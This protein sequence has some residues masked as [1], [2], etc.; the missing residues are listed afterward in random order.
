MVE[1]RDFIGQMWTEFTS[2]LVQEGWNCSDDSVQLRAGVWWY[3]MTGQEE[4]DILIDDSVVEK[5]K[6]K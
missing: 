3:G 4:E 6:M 5:I 2:I 1:S